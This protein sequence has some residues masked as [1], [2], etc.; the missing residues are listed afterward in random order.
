[1]QAPTSKGLGTR[2]ILASVMQQLGGTASFA[3]LSGGLKFTMTAALG[4]STAARASERQAKSAQKQAK[5][6][7]EQR[8]VLNS[9][10][11]AQRLLLVEDETLV[12]MMMKDTLTEL[13]FHVIGPIGKVDDAIAELK[14]EPFHAAVLDVNLRGEM[15]YSLADEIAG[16]G[17]PFVFVTGYGSEAID[18]RFADI[19]VLQKPV[20]R[21]ALQRILL[22]TKPESLSGPLRDRP[23]AA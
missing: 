21:A 17:V 11:G 22:P 9:V 8:N 2:V 4:D 1:V 12:G 7:G 3:W 18:T 15:I 19:P 20:D 14:G 5:G 23:P 13:G 16:R 10:N 6:G